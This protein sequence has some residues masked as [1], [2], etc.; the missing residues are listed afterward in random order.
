MLKNISLYGLLFLI[1]I[2]FN[3]C[4][5]DKTDLSESPDDLVLNILVDINLRPEA[6]YYIVL[7]NPESE[8]IY[9]A[10]P[11]YFGYGYLRGDK[12]KGNTINLHFILVNELENNTTD[13]KSFF[14][15]PI[16]LGIKINDDNLKQTK[17]TSGTVELSFE[18][19][20]E[21]DII[22]RTAKNQ[23]QGFTQTLFE[24]TATQP[25]LGGETFESDQYFYACF[26][27]GNTASY[28]L[29][30]VPNSLSHTIDFTN[31]DTQLAKHT[32]SKT[33]GGATITHVDVQAYNN[34]YLRFNYVELFNLNDFSIFPSSD[35]DIFVPRGETAIMYYVQ[36]FTFE[37]T[38]HIFNNWYY[39]GVFNGDIN[40]LDA[41]LKTVSR[42]GK[43]PIIE[44][45]VDAYDIAGIVFK[46]EGFQWTLYSPSTSSFYIP[47][48]PTELANKLP[49]AMNL[50]QLFL[51]Q[52]GGTVK[53]F[54]FDQFVGYEEILSVYLNE[55]KLEL[56]NSYRTQEQEF[57]NK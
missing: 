8:P 41:G 26:Q 40:L 37:T 15:V 18:N 44:S 1:L 39:S 42:V 9:W 17:L 14:D 29:E 2:A 21:F 32:F 46:S 28:K 11:N 47:D 45:D 13:I 48:I 50:H 5:K 31:L 3:S 20:P 22:S 49:G 16:G 12:I 25:E 19:I 55:T 30:R 23:E 6:T 57:S 10:I 7:E 24:T 27:T 34:P 54:D 35:F 36:N 33:I 4:R 52:D 43:L 56:G 53:L 38:D 51:N